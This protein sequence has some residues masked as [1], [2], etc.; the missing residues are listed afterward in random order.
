MSKAVISK[1]RFATDTVQFIHH[2]VILPFRF[3][4]LAR[5]P[6]HIKQPETTR[7]MP[8]KLPFE[9]PSKCRPLSHTFQRFPPAPPI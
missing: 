1:K 8:T 4:S 5:P 3:P 7:H 6:Q 9:H 2:K